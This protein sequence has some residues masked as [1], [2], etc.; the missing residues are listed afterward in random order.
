MKVLRD[1]DI[2]DQF[3][4]T[5]LVRAER[6]VWIA[7]ANLKAT[8]LRYGNRFISFPDLMSILVNR[9]VSLRIIHAELPSRPFRDKYEHLDMRGRLSAGVEFLHCIRVH[10]KI[11]IVDGSVAFVGS[12]N[13]T[14]AGIGAKSASRR[15]FEIGFLCEGEQDTVPFMEYFDDIWMGGRCNCCGLKDVCPAPVA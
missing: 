1:R 15:N 8:A 14:G 5:H 3:T 10:A 13:L 9:G 11:F 2:Y 7:T 4:T 6:F 12:P